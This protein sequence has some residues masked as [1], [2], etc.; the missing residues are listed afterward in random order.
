MLTAGYLHYHTFRLTC[1]GEHS[2][3]FLTRDGVRRILELARE[4]VAR[5]AKH[6]WASTRIEG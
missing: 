4:M 6:L 1:N 5:N 3:L 2:G